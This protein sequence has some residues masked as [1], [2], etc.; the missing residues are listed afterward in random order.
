MGTTDANADPRPVSSFRS[1]WTLFRA[2]GVPVRVDLSWLVICGLVIYIFATRFSALLGPYGTATVVAS[3]AVATL[4]FFASI[5]AHELGHAVT[6]LDRGIPV[7]SVTLFLL[8]GVTESTREPDRA[9]HEFVIVGIGPFISLVLASAFGLLFAISPTAS[10]YG[11]VTGYLAWLNLALAIFN[12]LPGYP[13]D[14]GR[15]LRAVLW[16]ITGRRHAATRWASRVGQVFAAALLL[17]GLNGVVGGPVPEQEGPLRWVVEVFAANGLWGMLIGFFLLRG[18]VDAHRQA[19]ASQ[20]LARLDLR[21]VMGS[22][23][24]TL[25]ADLRLDRAA[26]ELEQRPSVPWPV[27]DPLAGAVGLRDLIA[28]PREQWAETSLRDVAAPFEEVTV[29]VGVSLDEAVSRLRAAPGQMLI[30]TEGRAPVGLL[31]R[32]LLGGL[33]Q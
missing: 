18:A 12:V 31:T 13:L 11:A 6:S 8:G 16:G 29:D 14:G 21:Q 2:R 1:G 28:V 7:A 32:S 20:D 15:L 17:G 23:P 30:V 3:A 33:E 5:V 4:L 10:P 9:R 27:G 19:T 22:V 26:L 25:P 24:P